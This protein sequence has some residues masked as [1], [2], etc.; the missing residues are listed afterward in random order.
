[1]L[2]HSF[3]TTLKD[4]VAAIKLQLTTKKP[5]YIL[6]AAA[7]TFVAVL[8]VLVTWRATHAQPAQNTISVSDEKGVQV[9]TS[10]SE[11]VNTS[12]ETIVE[13]GANSNN[14][15]SDTKITV[16]NESVVV[17]ENGSVHKVINNDSSTTVIDVKNKSSSNGSSNSSSSSSISVSSSSQGS[18]TGG[19]SSQ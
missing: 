6:I 16:N 4:N 19:G 14:T 2:K 18:S 9:Q 15:A 5:S 13:Q 12:T 8:L 17:P 1:M 10:E 3:A 7:V 11:S